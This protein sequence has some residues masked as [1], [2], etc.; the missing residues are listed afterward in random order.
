MNK[1]KQRVPF[2]QEIRLEMFSSICFG[3][4]TK[5]G[6]YHKYGYVFESYPVQSKKTDIL[7]EYEQARKNNEKSVRKSKGKANP[8]DSQRSSKKGSAARDEASLSPRPV[9]PDDFNGDTFKAWFGRSKIVRGKSQPLIHYHGS[10]TFGIDNS[11]PWA[12]SNGDLG[13]RTGSPMAA[14][15]HFFALDGQEAAGYSKGT[16]NV[17]AVAI[18]MKKPF[19]TEG[20]KLPTFNSLEEAQAFRKRK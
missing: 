15:G 3:C 17:K 16:C 4:N 20:H 9:R 2:G 5:S 11:S 1:P 7:L 8:G 14:L 6:C 19:Y 12:F 18:R 13:K 10:A